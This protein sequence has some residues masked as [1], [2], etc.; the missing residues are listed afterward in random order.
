MSGMKVNFNNLR[1]Q[2]MFRYDS[3]AEKLNAAIRKEGQN[4]CYLDEFGHIEKGTIVID[5][6]H[7]QKEMEDLRSLIGSIGAT[8]QP[9]DEDFKDVYEEAYP[10]A[11]EK[12][13]VYFN[14]E[15]E[16]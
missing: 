16:A 2:A 14:E 4:T 7:I 6:D 10:M 15:V 8:Y 3:L 11:T 1:K 9:D 5:A 12:R 13:M